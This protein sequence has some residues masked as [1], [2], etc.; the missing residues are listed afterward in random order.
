ML[1]RLAPWAYHVG[2]GEFDVQTHKSLISTGGSAR[3]TPS[4][5]GGQEAADQM[6]ASTGTEEGASGAR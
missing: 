6:R 1:Y 3:S 2:R 5:G 4:S